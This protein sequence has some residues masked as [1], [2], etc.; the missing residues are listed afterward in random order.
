VFVGTGAG[1]FLAGLLI[2]RSGR[3]WHVL[4]ISSLL[5]IIILVIIKLRWT[6][7][8][9]PILCSPTLTYDCY[10]GNEPFGENV[11]EVIAIGIIIG[12][13]TGTLLVGLL[14]STLKEGK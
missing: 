9:Q 7:T 4:T 12:A 11:T 10:I 14:K 1:Q 13:M 6:G 2:S 5:Y 3:P 8:N